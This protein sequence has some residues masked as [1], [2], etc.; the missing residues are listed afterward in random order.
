MWSTFGSRSAWLRRLDGD[1]FERGQH[2]VDDAVFQS[3]FGGQVLVALDVTT[4][5][6]AL[7]VSPA[8]ISSISERI[9]RISFAWISMSDD[10]P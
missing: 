2:L 1:G 10:W 7:P 8:S 9:R 5:S 4:D 3:L 6:G